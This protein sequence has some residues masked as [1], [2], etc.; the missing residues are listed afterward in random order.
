MIDPIPLTPFYRHYACVAL[1]LCL[2]CTDGT[3]PSLSVR[4][5]G[6]RALPLTTE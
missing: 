5:V 1:G 2:A 6:I 3:A 4:V